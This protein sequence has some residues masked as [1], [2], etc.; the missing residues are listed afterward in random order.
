MHFFSKATALELNYKIID[1][2]K[3]ISFYESMHLQKNRKDWLT[4]PLSKCGK[5]DVVILPKI[6]DRLFVDFCVFTSVYL[7][8]PVAIIKFQIFSLFF[9]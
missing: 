9:Y 7:K 6:D 1:A 4:S 3:M 8:L 5:L 2:N